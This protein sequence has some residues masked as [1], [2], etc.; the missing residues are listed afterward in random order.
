MLPI[1]ITLQVTRP[2]DITVRNFRRI[3]RDAHQ[4]MGQKW[5]KEILPGHFKPGAESKYGYAPRTDRYLNDKREGKK[6][7]VSI[8]QRRRP[9]EA[10]RRAIE[11]GMSPLVYTGTLR[12]TIKQSAKVR[13]YPTR[14]TISLKVTDYAPL[15]RN[16]FTGI[17]AQG[18]KRKASPQPD[19]IKEIFTVTDGEAQEL[20]WY[21]QEKV[22]EG[23]AAA[24]VTRV[25]TFR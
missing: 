21:L 14:A 17:D 13:G 16:T 19:K 10:R 23:I 20:S 12:R 11:G 25:T 5:I 8:R 2:P 4:A 9:T 6:R 3:L 7:E 15:R 22:F 18:R 1:Y 24:P